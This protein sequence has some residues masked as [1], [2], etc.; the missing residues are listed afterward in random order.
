MRKIIN[1]TYVTLD[2]DMTN[3]QDWHMDYFGEEAGKA[4]TA[5]LVSSDALIMGR[6]TYEGFAPAWSGRAGADEFADRMNG[7]KKY[8]VSSTLREPDWENTS[9]ISGDVVAEVRKLKERPG[10]NILQYGFGPVTR[11]LLDNGLLDEFRVWLHPV[12]SG[13]AK[14]DDLLYRDAL[15]TKFTLNGTEVHSAGMIILSYVPVRPA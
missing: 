12:L 2:G 7:I 14:P 15:Q 13:K 10:G 5:Q 11:L 6:K 9:V 8:V 3:M 4:A 1:A